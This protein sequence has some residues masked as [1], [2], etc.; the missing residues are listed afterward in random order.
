MPKS[1]SSLGKISPLLLALAI[2]AL[3]LIFAVFV[4]VAKGGGRFGGIEEL[5]YESYLRN[6]E[7]LRGNTYVVK[8]KIESRLGYTEGKGS[9]IAV[10]LL[11]LGEGAVPVFVPQQS[12]RNLEVGQLYNI[13][14]R[15]ERDTLVAQDMEK[16]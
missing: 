16:L 7:T 5:P 13:K 14:V 3:V 9:V 11:K 15:V 12:G 1:K 8:G 2:P 4:I 6:V 10:K